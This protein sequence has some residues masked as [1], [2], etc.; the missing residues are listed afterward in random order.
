VEPGRY[1]VPMSDLPTGTA[2]LLFTDLE[3][4]YREYAGETSRLIPHL[5]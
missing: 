3:G 1:V 5:W 4:P 2:T